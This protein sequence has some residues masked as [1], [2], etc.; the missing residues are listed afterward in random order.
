MPMVTVNMWYHVGSARERTGRTGFAHLFEHLMFMGSGHVKPGEFDAV[1]RIG[2]RRQQ[3]VDD[4][5]PHQL[6]DQRPGQL[7]RARA[8]PRI[9]SHG[10]S[11][12][13]D[14]AA[15][16][17]TPSATSSRTSGARSVENRPYGTADVVLGE[18]LYPDGHPYHWP[19]IGYMDD[20]TAASYD[21]AQPARGAASSSVLARAARP[22]RDAGRLSLGDFVRADPRAISPRISRSSR[23]PVP[24]RRGAVPRAQDPRCEIRVQRRGRALLR[25][26]ERRGRAARPERHWRPRTGSL[27]TTAC[28]RRRRARGLM[29]DAGDVAGAAVGECPPR[30]ACDQEL[31]ARP[32]G[33]RSAP[34]PASGTCSRCFVNSARSRASPSRSRSRETLRRGRDPSRHGARVLGERCCRRRSASGCGPT[35]STCGGRS[36]AHR[37]PRGRSSHRP[38]ARQRVDADPPRRAGVR[39]SRRHSDVEPGPHGESIRG[40]SD[41]LAVPNATRVSQRANIA[42]LELGGKGGCRGSGGLRTAGGWRTPWR[43]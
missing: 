13:H 29:S 38:V 27:N 43:G 42:R 22:A 36:V 40:C 25:W 5:R 35:S 10:L 15:R 8:V 12:R 1:A 34:A 6:L 16:P 19:V 4:Q 3:R 26:K 28:L 39:A 18:M 11:A 17:S 41:P 23:A 30:D 37:N 24:H 32:R 7:A 2:R 33:G 14:D 21:D 9:G 31:G 20:L